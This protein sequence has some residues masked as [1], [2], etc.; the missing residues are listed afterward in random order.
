MK[1]IPAPMCWE[2]FAG[3]MAPWQTFC[4]ALLCEWIRPV[5]VKNWFRE[6]QR[7]ANWTWS[8]DQFLRSACRILSIR[9]KRKACETQWAWLIL[10]DKGQYKSSQST[11][12]N[13][14]RQNTW[15]TQTR[16]QPPNPCVTKG[17]HSPWL[18][19]NFGVWGKWR[20]ILR[21]HWPTSLGYYL[22]QKRG[23]SC[24]R[25]WA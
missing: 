5:C 8:K 18:T 14:S 9:P 19:W 3:C 20:Q 21:T 11:V 22:S 10:H 17:S 1:P 13:H 7:S 6:E 12:S 25:V 16:I 15:C 4:W 23:Q 2:G 24:I